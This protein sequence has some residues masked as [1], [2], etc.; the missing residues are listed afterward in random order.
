MC[1][2]EVIFNSKLQVNTVF[3]PMFVRVNSAH[4]AGH[5]GIC[6]E[7]SQCSAAH[8]THTGISACFQFIRTTFPAIEVLIGRNKHAETCRKATMID[9]IFMNYTTFLVFYLSDC[10]LF[11]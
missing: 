4:L 11:F 6:R 3:F 5:E 8:V 7:H 9:T 1:D 10:S 2:K